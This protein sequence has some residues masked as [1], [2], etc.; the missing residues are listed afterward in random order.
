[1]LRSDNPVLSSLNVRYV[2]VPRGER[3]T[4]GS[5]LRP[6]FE[7]AHVRVYENMQA[8]PRAYFS[9]RVHAELDPR[10]VL[11]RVTTPGFDGRREAVVE[12][13]GVPPL[14]ATAAAAWCK[15]IR[16]SPNEL[17]VRTLTTEPRFLVVS[18]MYMPGWHADID[19]TPATV[20]RTNYL[21][22]GVVVPAGHHVVRFVYRPRSVMLGAAVSAVA[23]IVVGVL[24]VSASLRARD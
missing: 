3:V 22:R 2:L 11:E 19:G 13:D 23:L 20:Y 4:L 10:A 15:A 21:F 9:G 18:E 7:N 6:V 17:H 8:Y 16:S 5:H 1:L 12:S 14:A 24:L